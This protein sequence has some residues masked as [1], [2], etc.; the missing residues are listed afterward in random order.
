MIL[1]FKSQFAKIIEVQGPRLRQIWVD[2]LLT[3]K[4]E[5]RLRQIY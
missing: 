5:T 4:P 2:L 3:E 1:N